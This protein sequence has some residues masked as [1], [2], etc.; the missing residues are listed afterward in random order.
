MLHAYLFSMLSNCYLFLIGFIVLFNF[1]DMHMQ[2]SGERP[3]FGR[4]GGSYGAG[5][6]GGSGSFE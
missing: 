6:A 1:L 3:G 2:G 4:G 5:P